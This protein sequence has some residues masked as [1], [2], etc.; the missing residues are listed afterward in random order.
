MLTRYH[1]LTISSSTKVDMMLREIALDML[2]E[3]I[4]GIISG[5]MEPRAICTR[6]VTVWENVAFCVQENP[7]IPRNDFDKYLEY[8]TSQVEWVCNTFACS[9]LYHSFK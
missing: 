7:N 6:Q 4:I 8:I 3:V 9:D 2:R 1:A 5:Q